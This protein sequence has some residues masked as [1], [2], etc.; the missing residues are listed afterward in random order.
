MADLTEDNVYRGSSAYNGLNVPEEL[1]AER[2]REKSDA[3][4]M[5]PVIEEAAEYLRS[6]VAQYKTIDCIPHEVLSDPTLFMNA[7]A[8][9]KQTVANLEPILGRLEELI[10]Q[11]KR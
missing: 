9:N 3:E 5:M 4:L 1:K 7:V 10:K 2:Q 11:Y 8:A 6:S